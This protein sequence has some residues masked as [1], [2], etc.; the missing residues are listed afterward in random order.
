[1]KEIRYRIDTDY[2]TKGRV[3][4]HRK[5]KTDAGMNFETWVN[6]NKTWKQTELAHDA[7]YE[8]TI[9][10]PYIANE[11]AE[12]LIDFITKNITVDTYYEPNS[13]EAFLL[14]EYLNKNLSS[15]NKWELE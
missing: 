13:K 4:I 15:G 3:V 2:L 9:D 5:I 10:S 12:D 11:K 1:M 6:S 14:Q 8:G 7:Y